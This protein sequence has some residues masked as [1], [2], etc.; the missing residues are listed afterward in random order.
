MRQR[1]FGALLSGGAIAV[2]PS[3]AFGQTTTGK[4]QAGGTSPIGVEEI[5]VTAQKRSESI[6]NVPIA[7]SAATA[8]SLERK[9]IESTVD[10]AEAVPG[11]MVS[12]SIGFALPRLR[13]VGNIVNSTGLD[14]SVA[15]YVDGVYIAS[16][17]GASTLFNNI[18]R[19][20]VLKGPQGTLYGRNA[21]GGVI[22]VIT[23]NPSR[24]FKG[25]V[26][27]GYGNYDTV[28]GGGYVT[29][30]LTSKLAAD[31]AVYYQDTNK[32]YGTNFLAGGNY[33]GRRTGQGYEFAVRS[34]WLWLPTEKD[35]ITFS[36]DYSRRNRA[37]GMRIAPGT[38]ALGGAT[39]T[40]TNPWDSQLLDKPIAKNKDGGGS[41]RFEH[42]FG[43]FRALSL[44]AY[45]KQSHFYSIPVAAGVTR[46]DS[47]ADYEQFS[48]EVQVQSPN[49]SKVHWVAGL[50][51][52]RST[53]D[54]DPTI[55][56]LPILAPIILASESK[57][58]LESA[59]IFGQ[60]TLP[61]TSQTNLTLGARYTDEKRSIRGS[62]GIAAPVIQLF[63]FPKTKEKFDRV[64]WRVAV[65]HHFTE[66]LMVY[67]SHSRGIKGG[68]FNQASPVAAEITSTVLPEVLDSL[69]VG[70]KS[71][72]F[73]NRVRLNISGFSY[74]YKDIQTPEYSATGG[75]LITNA[76]TADV[77]GI[78][79]DVEIAATDR[80]VLSGGIEL[81]RP[82]FK[83]F[84]NAPFTPPNPFPPGGNCFVGGN[85]T[86]PCRADASGNDL[87]YSPRVTFNVG[88]NYSIPTERLG[89]FNLDLNYYYN[90]G[91]FA[92]STNFLRQKAYHLLSGTVAW[93]LPGEQV[94]VSVWGRNLLDEAYAPFL[95]ESTVVSGEVLAPPRTYGV[96]VALRF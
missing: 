37:Q 65:D 92:S 82:K 91:Y 44:S 14:N 29:G 55:Q 34:K 75:I 6:Q 73:Q 51:Y 3:A 13:G 42:D 83:S 67:A 10:L 17:S 80:F 23:K 19:V 47:A 76:V 87:P 78:D 16:M 35:E 84:P 50:Y 45:R 94:E 33:N 52:L 4:D 88:A 28:T 95:P 86:T 2:A 30:G 40:A 22:H 79:A 21:T 7:I 89:E 57:S 18:D 25:E 74:N 66:D 93:N 53:I 70:L 24:E 15:S 46:Q 27:G 43:G 62:A 54:V 96:K 20:E 69:E 8:E 1:L 32:G 72:W 59:S 61:V 11:L 5:V 71:K 48:E 81:L 12:A 64:T 85:P 36:A 90:D 58:T 41:V 9:R 77:E 39:N 68:G 26:W 38:F 49:Q 31:L 56:I 60:V 63:P